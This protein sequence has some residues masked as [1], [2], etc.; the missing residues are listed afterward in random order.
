M[1]AS[2]Q[3]TKDYGLKEAGIACLA[4]LPYTHKLSDAGSGLQSL[5]KVHGDVRK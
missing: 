5:W 4:D 1:V 3:G 2:V